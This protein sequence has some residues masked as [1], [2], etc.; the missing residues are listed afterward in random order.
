VDKP[1]IIAE[2]KRLRE[3]L[4][5]QADKSATD[6]VNEFSKIAFTDRVDFLKPD[7]FFPGCYIYKSPDELTTVQRSLV[8]KVNTIW[9][10]CKRTIG[11]K[12]LEIERQ[13]F[14][15]LLSDKT[16]ALES[17]GRHFG[18]FDDK[19]KLQLQRQNPFMNASPA[20]LEKLKKSFINTMNQPAVI[21][22]KVV[23]NGK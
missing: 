13:E 17:M 8:E 4:T 18:I 23:K 19:I 7:D 6:V 22:G 2:F 9:R 16:K 20:Q 14:S 15:Y 5:E 12:K 10:V 1:A 21:E 11:G 3:R